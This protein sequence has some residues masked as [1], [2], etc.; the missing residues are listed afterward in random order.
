MPCVWIPN[1]NAYIGSTKDIHKNFL[2]A[3]FLRT[4][5]WKLYK[6]SLTVEQTNVYSRYGELYSNENEYFSDS[7][8]LDESHKHN[9]EGRNHKIMHTT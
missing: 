7:H 3:L 1:R 8:N 9:V 5:K 2:A 6:C 4:P